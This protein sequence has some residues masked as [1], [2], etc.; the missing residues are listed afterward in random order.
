MKAFIISTGNLLNPT[1]VLRW[2]TMV[3][4]T[5]VWRTLCVLILYSSCFHCNA[6]SIVNTFEGTQGEDEIFNHLIVH[7]NTSKVYIGAV[8]RLYQLSPDLQLGRQAVTGPQLDNY[9]CPVS[10]ISRRTKK[11][12][13]NWMCPDINKKLTSNWNKVL[14]IDYSHAA[15]IACGSLFQGVCAVHKLDDISSFEIPQKEAVV[16]NNSTASTF[17]FIAPGPV[18]NPETHVINVGATY[19]NNGPYRSDVPAVSSRS[20]A[21]GNIFRIASMTVTTATR[22]RVNS[23]AREHYFITYVY[24]FSSHGYSFF[25]TYQ[26]KDTLKKDMYISKLI[27]ICQNDTDYYS[28][29]E[30]PLECHGANGTDYNLVQAAFLGKPGSDLAVQLGIT[31]QDDVLYAVFAKSAKEQHVYN[32]PGSNSALCV[33]SMKD[34]QHKFKSNIQNCFRGRGVT[35]LDFVRPSLKCVPTQIIINDNFC[36][37]DV[38]E[39]LGGSIP[40]M[41]KPVLTFKNNLLTSVAATSTHIY[42]VVFLGTANGHLLKVA[43]ESL[44]S[45]FQYDDLVIDSGSKVNAD[46]KF[47]RA[48]K[49]IYVMTKRKV[50]KVK[51]QDCSQYKT[52][53]TCLGAKDPYCGWC[54]LENKCSLLNDCSHVQ[55]GQKKQISWQSY[56]AGRCTT[57]KKVIPHQIQKTTVRLLDLEIDDLSNFPGPFLCT[58]K[59]FG[60]IFETNATKTQKGVVCLTPQIDHFSR[61]HH[62][63]AKLSV[64][65]ESGLDYVSTNLTFYDC[66]RYFSCTEC[67]SSPFPCDWCVAGHRCTHD[68]GENCRNEILINGVNTIGPSL[69]SG[70]NFCPRINSTLN[71]AVEI[72]VPSGT[73][74]KI[75]VRVDNMQKIILESKLVCQ[76]NIEG[77]ATQVPA[78]LVAHIIY[79]DA[80]EFTYTSRAPNTTVSFAVIWDSYKPLDNPLEIHVLVYQCRGMADNCG[81]CLALLPPKYNCGWC[82]DQESCEVKEQCGKPG[83][84]VEWLNRNKTCPNPTIRSFQPTSGPFEGG[85]NVTILGINLGKSFADIEKGVIVAGIPCT[86]YMERYVNTKEIVCKVG[87][88]ELPLNEPISGPVTVTVFHKYTAV[89]SYD[90]KYVY[91]TITSIFPQIGPMS[92]GTKLEIRG[93]YMDAG[94][95]IEVFLGDKPCKVIL[96]SRKYAECITPASS[97]TGVAVLKMVFDA[98]ERKFEKGTFEYRINPTITSVES[99]VAGYGIPQGIPAGGI[100]ITVKG[101]NLKDI[102]DPKFYVSVNGQDYVNRCHIVP[103]AP[104]TM[105]C[106]SPVIPQEAISFESDLPVKLEYGL[107]M[108]N[109]TDLRNLSARREFRPF[110]LYPNPVYEPFTNEGGIKFYKNEYM[111]IDGKNLDRAGQKSDVIVRIG[112]GYCNVTSMSRSQ[113]TCRPP[114]TKPMAL[115][116]DGQID[117]DGIP[118]VLFR[119]RYKIQYNIRNEEILKLRYVGRIRFRV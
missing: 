14:L 83:K 106:K 26:K 82:R 4:F 111:T 80:M 39:P 57:I 55:K 108:D 77:R 98:G 54:P 116:A 97:R 20:L 51:L 17:A 115:K 110:Y 113:L 94:S 41:A 96:T 93:E 36:G 86:P 11:L 37:E 24:G 1:S 9:D 79:C 5:M 19:T 35:G 105:R 30:I 62:F 33:Y 85:T 63:T 107:I 99:G 71:G 109:V 112:A 101:K 13:D 102:Q 45:A 75:N 34:I 59:A 56:K 92:G 60:R 50:S 65:Q 84:A 18:K 40:M 25:V 58:F 90:Y 16:A 10:S 3:D 12:T 43:V 28:Y 38:N 88:P 7:D 53:S 95:H 23:L 70:P 44:I 61:E 103:E 72:L 8:N 31:V 100:V 27:R 29:T 91:P 15:L 114:K 22:L 68:T 46:L 49:H 117:S 6:N 67:V 119:E 2:C 104:N 87:K 21:P 64:R 81:T 32:K 78:Q 76:F 69:R 48:K 73:S 74:K 42:T 118:Q 89:S 47:D 52:C 66:S